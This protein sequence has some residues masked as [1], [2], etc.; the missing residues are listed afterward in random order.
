VDAALLDALEAAAK[1]EGAVVELV[2]P[3]ISGVTD[4]A[5]KMRPARQ[6]IN[7]GPS[8][9]YDAVAVLASPTG[10][11][12]LMNEST[13]KDFM[14]D[15]FAHAKFIAYGEESRPLLE[16]AGATPD[17]GCLALRKPEDARRFI[18]ICAELRFWEREA[19]VQKA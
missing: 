17:G 10:M 4:S 12:I 18:K 6:K 15:A 13:A 9:L 1:A 8:V 16:K 2:A 5:G 11:D 7:G 14:S 3:R 19:K